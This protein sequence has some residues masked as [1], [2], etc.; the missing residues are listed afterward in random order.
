MKRL[1]ICGKNAIACKATEYTF[2]VIT[3][4]GLDLRLGTI[5]VAGDNGVDTWQPSLRKVSN[6][7]GLPIYPSLSSAS[8]TQDDIVVSLEY[9]KVIRPTDLNHARAF[10][11]HFSNLPKYR[12][13]LTSVWPI[14]NGE[15][16]AGATLH[17]LTPGI[18][19]GPIVDQVLF[20]IPEFMTS[21]DLYRSYSAYGYELY[22]RNL[23]KIVS[24]DYVARTQDP[25]LASYY[26]RS[27][28]NFAELELP[29]FDQ[30]AAQL[31]AYVQSLVFEPYQ[32]PVFHGK[33]VV[34][35]DVLVWDAGKE[36]LPPPAQVVIEDSEHAVVSC[37]DGYVRLRFHP[38]KA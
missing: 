17:E 14:R 37:L 12:G 1:V 30:P 2:D 28:V 23:G 22:K 29:P 21:F 11:I 10:N 19:D 3:I 26:K 25:S 27:S 33:R 35:C 8:L 15:K 31:R 6:Q 24:G 38:D 5:P 7:L 36:S 4:N 18:D 32:L 9:D 20:D 16:Q 13:C 34:E